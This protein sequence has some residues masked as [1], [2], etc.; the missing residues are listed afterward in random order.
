MIEVKG[1][2]WDLFDPAT[3]ALAHGCNARGVMGAGFALQV[4]TRYPDCYTAYNLA[5]ITRDD[6]ELG[7]VLPW[8][9]R[10]N[11]VVIYN[12]IT[13]IE[14]GPNGDL[15][16]V[17]RSM[18]IALEDARN[19][20]LDTIICPRIG[21]GIAKLPWEHVRRALTLAEASYPEVSILAVTL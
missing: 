19:R 6:I 3:M 16:A 21:A 12:L 4:R 9:D 10:E 13:Q 7:H 20:H 15:P 8:W 5:C 17:A 11:G 18:A 2:V 1:D 14:P